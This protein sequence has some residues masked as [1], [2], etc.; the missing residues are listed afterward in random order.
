MANIIVFQANDSFLKIKSC[1]YIW[2]ERR[3]NLKI[4]VEILLLT[5]SVSNK[6][7][8]KQRLQN[9]YKQTYIHR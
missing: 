1:L 3:I 2:L 6:D 5:Q 8:E 7:N 9:Y 4:F